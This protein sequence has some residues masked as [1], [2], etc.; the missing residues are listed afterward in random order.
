M[1]QYELANAGAVAESSGRE[2]LLERDM[3][4][5]IASRSGWRVLAL[6]FAGL[7]GLSATIATVILTAQAQP[8]NQLAA[9]GQGIVTGVPVAVALYA[10]RRGPYPRFA[11]LLLAAA[12]VWAVVGLSQSMRSVPYSVGRVAEWLVQPLVIYA[13]LAFPAGRLRSTRERVVVAASAAVV[14]VLYLP[15]ALLVDQY[16][17]PAPWTSCTA[18]CPH[19]AF[20]VSAS[21]PGFINSVLLPTR[22]LA[23]QLLF[24]ATVLILISRMRG[25]SRLMRRAQGP[26]LT[27]AIAL[28][29][30]QTVYL[31]E[32]RAGVIGVPLDVVSWIWLLTLPGL[33]IAFLVGIVR[34][35]LF[36]AA[37]GSVWVTATGEPAELPEPGSGLDF[38][39]L[40][41]SRGQ[42]V[43]IVHDEALSEC[44]PLVQAAGTHMLVELDNHS[45]QAQVRTSI[46]EL[47]ESRT[48]ALAAGESARR[49]LRQDL[50]DGAQQRLVGLLVRLELAGPQVQRDPEGGARLLH[51]LADEV[52]RTL[53]DIRVLSHGLEPS[54]LNEQ[55][56][57]GRSAPWSRTPR[58]KR[59]ST[60]TASAAIHRRSRR[61]C[62]SSAWRHS[63]TRTSTR[64][65]QRRSR[66]RCTSARSSASRCATTGM[67]LTRARSGPAWAWR[68]CAS[69]WPPSA[70]ASQSRR[71]LDPPQC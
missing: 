20:M 5:S 68:A 1:T 56:L 27:A 29:I 11:Y 44:R 14:A 18:S 16:P 15:S 43:A 64:A 54:V 53:A 49:K 17:L 33:V 24:L 34:W 35:R 38:T 51:D 69:D 63:R 6:A 47:A 25:A 61:V 32:R 55:D 65:G 67:D 36:T 2:G 46:R 60:L 7:V 39:E 71:P 10:C 21:Q 4:R 59:S 41:G 48:Q 28:L 42:A 31:I 70:V 12:V 52:E 58:S 23:A 50:H 37:E 22:E 62:T 66:S 8:H 30:A 19:N 13:L 40:I 3:S 26:V 9:L 57:A 45:L